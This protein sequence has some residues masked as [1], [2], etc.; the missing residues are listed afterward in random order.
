MQF[1]GKGPYAGITLLHKVGN[2]G[3][4]GY[5]LRSPARSAFWERKLV[6]CYH[7]F[8]ALFSILDYMLLEGMG[9]T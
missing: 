7:C 6:M 5:F 8:I 2:V 4:A 9:C 1:E 3:Q